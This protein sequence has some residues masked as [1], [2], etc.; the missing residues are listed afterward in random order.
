VSTY[1]PNQNS[2]HGQDE[3]LQKILVVDDEESTRRL[4]ERIL[5]SAGHHVELARGG[6]EAVHRLEEESFDLVITDL[7]M[8]VVD[9]AEVLRRAKELDP[10]CEVIV[11]TGYASVD[12]A[13]KLMKQGAYDYLSKPFSLERISILVERALEKRKL[14][15]AARERDS[16][17][18]LS[19]L[20][21]MTEVHN[22]RAFDQFLSAEMSRSRR[23]GRPLSLL[24]IDLDNLKAINDTFGHQ[25]GDTVLKQA[26]SA[27]KRS[28]RSCDIV[29]RYGGDEFAIL[30]L[31][32]S[33]THAITTASRLHR[34]VGG[35]GGDAGAP[36]VLNERAT[37]I[38]VGV[39]TYPTDAGDMDEL[40]TKADRAL[41]AA[42]ASG[43]DC[44][45]AAR[46]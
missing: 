29:A 4:L 27:L 13:V 44:V 45:R 24:M 2:Y 36:G 21:C 40:V 25:A 42:K 46:P 16:Y 10:H 15:Q 12:S 37:T 41:Y 33:K 35:Q 34:L 18:R 39:A 1:P 19:Q 31:E 14:L 7:R 6:S 22:R 38:S 26:A 8:P 32:T 17:K 30:L 9:G 23:Y 20:D 3:R 11:I 5:G 43:G 28:V